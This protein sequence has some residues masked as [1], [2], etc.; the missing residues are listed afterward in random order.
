MSEKKTLSKRIQEWSKQNTRI[1]NLRLNKHKESDVIEQLEKQESMSRYI[2][3]LIR[4]DLANKGQP[5]K[6][7]TLSDLSLLMNE[8][9]IARLEF[10][11][12]VGTTTIWKATKKDI[13]NDTR[14]VKHWFRDIDN[15]IIAQVKVR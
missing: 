7:I 12:G 6:V 1:V 2:I 15:N 4:Q 10:S 13:E 5:Q 8:G 11:T 14:V 3:D 9:E